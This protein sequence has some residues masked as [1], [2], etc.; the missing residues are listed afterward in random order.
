MELFE[1][2]NITQIVNRFK[3]VL[4]QK[5]VKQI[6][7]SKNILKITARAFYKILNPKF[8]GDTKFFK[9]NLAI[10]K[11]IF[12]WT[13]ENDE[14]DPIG[15][16]PTISNH[17]SNKNELAGLSNGE[18]VTLYSKITEYFKKSNINLCKF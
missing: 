11:K 9:K 16:E 2:S 10:Y 1:F 15:N 5:K 14:Y 6:D 18:L 12:E 7:F 3:T 8:F 4:K 17:M 13:K